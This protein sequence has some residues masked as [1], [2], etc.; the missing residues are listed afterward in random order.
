MDYFDSHEGIISK[1]WTSGG[2]DSGWS[3][4]ILLY[5]GNYVDQ[6]FLRMTIFIDLESPITIDQSNG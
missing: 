4:D 3:F 6:K 1:I 5:D 2:W